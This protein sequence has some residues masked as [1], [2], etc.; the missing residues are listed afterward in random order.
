MQSPRQWFHIGGLHG[1]AERV[2]LKGVHVDIE[3]A[4]QRIRGLALGVSAAAGIRG[5]R[6]LAEH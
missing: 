6:F 1:F 5:G 3:V 2:W 4:A